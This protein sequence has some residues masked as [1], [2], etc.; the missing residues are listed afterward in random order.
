[1]I[2]ATAWAA[3]GGVV[4]GALAIVV[5]LEQTLLW[6]EALGLL[7]FAAGLASVAALG[8]WVGV[9]REAL[10]EYDARHGTAPS[11]TPDRSASSR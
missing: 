10:R 6:P 11:A 8:T 5:L 4:G 3:L 1:M 2:H 7:E 9:N